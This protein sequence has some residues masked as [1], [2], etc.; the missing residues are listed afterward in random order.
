VRFFQRAVYAV[1]SFAFAAH[2]FSQ[3]N[4]SGTFS[5]QVADPSGA[6]VA[7]AL[8]RV[9]EPETGVG[10][11]V[12]S[13]ADTAQTTPIVATLALRIHPLIVIISRI[14]Q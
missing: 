13:H 1:S 7:N 6:A 10:G 3:V 8:V 5:G 12:L 9:T 4:A 2:L 14:S 11:A